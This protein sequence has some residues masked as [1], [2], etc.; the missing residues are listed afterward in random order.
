MPIMRSMSPVTSSNVI[1][2]C[3]ARASGAVMML[4]FTFCVFDFEQV[5]FI[6]RG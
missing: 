1:Q 3:E 2:G 6:R 4:M 5:F